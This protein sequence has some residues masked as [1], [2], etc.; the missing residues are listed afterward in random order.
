MEDLSAVYVLSTNADLAIA[1]HLPLI[2]NLIALSFYL[3]CTDTPYNWTK[4]WIRALAI[5]S[6]PVLEE[7]TSDT[8]PA[9]TRPFRD[10]G[11]LVDLDFS[12]ELN[13]EGKKP[14]E[15]DEDADYMK[16]DLDEVDHSNLLSRLE[17]SKRD[18][19]WVPCQLN[20]AQPDTNQSRVLSVQRGP[21][22]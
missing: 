18:K 22:S 4:H 2:P 3:R 9:V 7:N 16:V 8:D 11:A 14:T 21:T 19:H 17:H 5:S 20:H 1:T 15:E 12:Q 13:V 6:V 10:S